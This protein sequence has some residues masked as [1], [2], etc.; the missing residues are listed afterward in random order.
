MKTSKS[1]DEN[2]S[3]TQFIS[4][5]ENYEETRNF[6]RKSEKP[7]NQNIRFTRETMAMTNL[8]SQESK[9]G[10]REGTNNGNGKLNNNKNHNENDPK[11]KNTYDFENSLDLI[12]SSSQIHKRK[13]GKNTDDYE[14][15]H[16]I[17]KKCLSNIASKG[18]M[19]EKI[20]NLESPV[21]SNSPSDITKQT[22]TFGNSMQ[23]FQSSRENADSSG[24]ILQSVISMFQT[25]TTMRLVNEQ[26]LQQKTF[27]T[28]KIESD[29]VLN[30]TA[31]APPGA[32]IDHKKNVAHK[33][34]KKHYRQAKLK[35]DCL[36]FIGFALVF[37]RLRKLL[38]GECR[39][40]SKMDFLNPIYSTKLL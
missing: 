33:K 4:D 14:V 27:N 10:R 31:S 39:N 21:V 20:V 16:E 8:L 13:K 36:L 18:S 7:T 22:P 25:S 5:Q 1:I 38:L 26:N 2:S 19:S 30:K 40:K 29:V 3:E 24:N 6:E 15:N 11:G 12:I 35:C 9:S 32:H 23:Q 34:K 17:L 28:G 37:K